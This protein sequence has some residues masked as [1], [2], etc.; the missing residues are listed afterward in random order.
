MQPTNEDELA[1]MLYTS[2]YS[3]KPCFIRYPRGKAE[4]V[5]MKEEPQSIEIGKALELEA[6]D[7][8]IVIWGFGDMLKSAKQAAEILTIHPFMAGEVF[9]FLILKILIVFHIT[10]TSVHGKTSGGL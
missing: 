10:Y 5:P 1:D 9:T 8:S 7:G 6:S 3:G 4:G 2:V